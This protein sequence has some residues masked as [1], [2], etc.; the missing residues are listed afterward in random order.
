MRLETYIARKLREIWGF[1][2]VFSTLWRFCSHGKRASG[3]R[4]QVSGLQVSGFSCQSGLSNLCELPASCV[5]GPCGGAAEKKKRG[6]IAGAPL[7]WSSLK[8]R[9][10][11]RQLPSQV[12]RIPP[13]AIADPLVGI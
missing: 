5:K 7:V 11:P 3:E 2:G 13:T 6:A 12:H 8:A 9:A 10:L 4:L 1:R